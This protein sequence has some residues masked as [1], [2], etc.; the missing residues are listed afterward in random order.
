MKTSGFRLMNL[1]MLDIFL[2]ECI[3]PLDVHNQ[4]SRFFFGMG[5]RYLYGFVEN[6]NW[7]SRFELNYAP[8]VNCKNVFWTFLT[9]WTYSTEILFIICSWI[10]T[11]YTWVLLCL[12]YFDWI[13][14]LDELQESVFRT[15]LLKFYIWLWLSIKIT[16][17]V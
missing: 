9:G 3:M 16:D 2:N 11:D 7:Q 6:S 12:T 14:S 10:V 15:F 17:Q 5:W 13:M 4:F 1:V 8:W